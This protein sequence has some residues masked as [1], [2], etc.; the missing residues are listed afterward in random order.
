MKRLLLIVCI[1]A[2]GQ[3]APSQEWVVA[4]PDGRNVLSLSI[5]EGRL[6]W[7]VK[8]EDASI[9]ERSPLGVRRHD[10]TFS[11]GLKVVGATGIRDVREDYRMP[12]G[13]RREH[14]VRGREQAVTF[15]NARNAQLEVILR[16]HD[17]G[18]AIR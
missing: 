12:H 7:Q 3:P 13:K 4:S 10:Q 18:V 1:L 11:D 15:A 16:A 9:L 2:S 8:W 5:T 14:H 6:V 17:D